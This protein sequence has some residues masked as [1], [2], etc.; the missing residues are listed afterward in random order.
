MNQSG[1]EAGLAKGELEGAIVVAG[2]FD[3]D[4]DG[5]Q[6]MVVH[7]LPNAVDGGLQL[8]ALMFEGG[9]LE[10][11]LAVE[12]GEQVA[13]SGLGAV[14]GDYAKVFG[15]HLLNARRQLPVGLL[16]NERLACLGGSLGSG[17]R[18]GLSF[19][20]EDCSLNPKGRAG[21]EKTLLFS[22]NPHTTA[23]SAHR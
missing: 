11:G 13:R 6:V 2:A 23:V 9:G 19:R 15:A 12:V 16:Q 8:A 17:T 3:G 4:D 5:A 21:E 22:A 14:D 7:G 10:D 18:H 20:L 1:F